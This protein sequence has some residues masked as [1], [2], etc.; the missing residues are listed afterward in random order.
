MK[1]SAIPCS[2]SVFSR[3]NGVKSIPKFSRFSSF[4]SFP[5]YPYSRY[6]VSSRPLFMASAAQTAPP[7]NSKS[8][9]FS[10]IYLCVLKSFN[11]IASIII[12]VRMIST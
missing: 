10:R 2:I 1:T 9:P 11:L 5:S 7:V 3:I 6:R 8:F 12:V 4:P